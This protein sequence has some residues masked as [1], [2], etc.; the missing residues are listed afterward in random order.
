LKKERRKER[1]SRSIA[2][3]TKTAGSHKVEIDLG[4]PDVSSTTDQKQKS[5]L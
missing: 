5:I 2:L 3:K 4:E 1:E